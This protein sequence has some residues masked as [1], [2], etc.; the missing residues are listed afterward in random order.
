MWPKEAGNFTPWLADHLTA[1]GEALGIELELPAREAPVGD[2]SLDI[3][4]RDLGRNRPVII[5]NQLQPTDHDHLGKMLTY[6]AGDDASVVAWIAQEMRE[7]HR[8]TLDWLN[9]HTDETIDFFC[10]ILQVFKNDD[11]RPPLP[12]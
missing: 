10:V 5:E 2:F 1:L 11:S 4:A 6:A 12:F 8:Q 3:L 9:Q 7:E